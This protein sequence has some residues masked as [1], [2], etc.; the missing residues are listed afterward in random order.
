[1][2]VRYLWAKAVR[3]VE[4]EGYRIYVTD[5]LRLIP[6]MMYM[7]TRW[8][9]VVGHARKPVESRSVD[10]IIDDVIGRLEE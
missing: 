8:A 4:E 2:F 7:S 10:E 6:Q 1:M 5:S 3:C 9:D